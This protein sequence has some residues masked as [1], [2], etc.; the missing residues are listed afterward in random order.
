[1]RLASSS[2]RR[3]R[4]IP[5]RLIVATAAM[6]ATGCGGN[7]SMKTTLSPQA[8][9]VQS[10]QPAFAYVLN[11]GSFD[12]GNG[13]ISSYTVNSCTGSL[14]P[15][16]PAT[17]ATG[18]SP[19]D[20]AVDPLGR[21]VYVA[22]LVSNA[23]DNA[24][25]SMYTIN[26]RT[27]VLTP[28]TPAT[29]PTGFF[30]QGIGIDPSGKFVYTANSDDNTVSMFT[31][32]STTGVLTPTR[33]PAAPAGMDPGSV[34]VD[35]SGRFAYVANQGDSTVSMYTIDQTTGVLTPTAPPT[36][37]AGGGPFGVTIAPSG[38]FAY[39][40]NAYGNNNVS[41]Y[42][43][44]SSTGVLTATAEG[45]APAGNSPTCVAV[46]PSGKFAYVVNRQDNTVSAYT[47]SSSSGNLSHI[48]TIA[49]GAQPWRVSADPSGKFVYVANESGSISIFALNSDGTLSSAGTVETPS[50]AFAITVVQARQ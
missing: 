14:T 5:V 31:I 48:G 47:I 41:E 6:L 40:P 8:E 34:T 42:N 12:W 11:Q 49:T 20:M 35:P 1:M 26:S 37:P 38:N 17:I 25:I 4:S 45:A 39:V 16:T 44:D 29:V 30:P 18:S 24:T 50:G 13:T 10:P 19:E 43:I 28:T 15:T 36:T 33:P 22:N 27:G 23:V 7:S 2:P 46:N 9:C 21:F 32:D 3:A